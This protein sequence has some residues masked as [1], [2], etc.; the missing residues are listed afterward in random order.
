MNLVEK[1]QKEAEDFM[2]KR[3]KTEK[4]ITKDFLKIIDDL[5]DE[6]A[7]EL[8]KQGNINL[9]YVTIIVQQVLMPVI[10][11][12]ASKQL[13]YLNNVIDNTFN[14][15]INQAQQLLSL[16]PLDI[17]PLEKDK[18]ERQNDYQDTLSALLLYSNQ[19]ITGLNNDLNNKL[20]SDITSMYIMSKNQNN[21][22]I[23]K[24]ERDTEKDSIFNTVLSGTV[25]A[26]YI[27]SSFN[28]IRNRADIISQTEVIR[29]LNSGI[30]LRYINEVKYVK[31]I[32]IQDNRVCR[33]CLSM[34]IN[35][36]G[37]YPVGS[38][39][40]PPLHP[41]CRCVLIPYDEKWLS[42]AY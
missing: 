18:M 41:R 10:Q 3:L 39:S 37:I 12:Y 24:S 20:N 32:A 6:I 42:I 26:K 40:P 30:L 21:P 31:W 5:E 19:L 38:I 14:A 22:S 34:S 1:L 11:K 35:D 13:D 4:N 25:I 33:N 29:A 9:N 2:A 23:N 7:T 28:N 17:P 27:K 15:G 16:T 36:D 8:S